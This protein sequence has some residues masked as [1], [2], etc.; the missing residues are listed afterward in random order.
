MEIKRDSEN[1][2]ASETIH[3]NDFDFDNHFIY[4]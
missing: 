3:G 2:T 4:I 1:E